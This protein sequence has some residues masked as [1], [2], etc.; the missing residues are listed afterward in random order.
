MSF[1]IAAKQVAPIVLA[2]GDP[3]RA[4]LV[5]ERYLEESTLITDIRNVLGYTG[6]YKGVPISVIATGMGGP[7]IGIYSYELFSQY[8]AQAII[9]IGTCGG[10]KEE[11]LPGDRIIALSASTDSAWAHQYNLKGTLS[12]VCDPKLLLCAAELDRDAH[13]GMVFSSDLFSSYN[14][15]GEESWRAWA[16]MGALAQD[17]E[18]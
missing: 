14:A 13:L 6:T 11:I 16:A 4:K 5:A 17:M 10:F 9:R 18:T 3:L 8:D 15:L 12:P 2:P 1:H 7:S